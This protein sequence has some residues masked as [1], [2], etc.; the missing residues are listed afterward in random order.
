MNLKMLAGSINIL[1]SRILYNGEEN[2]VKYKPDPRNTSI[3]QLT[4]DLENLV[5]VPAKNTYENWTDQNRG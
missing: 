5:E 2:A 1:N 4:R 3:V